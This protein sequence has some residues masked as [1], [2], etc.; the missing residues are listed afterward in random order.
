MEE[1][2]HAATVPLRRGPWRQG[3]A[4]VLAEALTPE[5]GD[6]GRVSGACLQAHQS[7]P[8]RLL[9]HPLGQA[10]PDPTPPQPGRDHVIVE[11]T[12][13]WVAALRSGAQGQASLSPDRMRPGV[14][15]HW[16]PSCC[17]ARVYTYITT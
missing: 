12:D 5:S 13:R 14:A 6:S 7:Q 4:A 8:A 9:D 17:G 16:L 3:K 1:H 11:P 15:T 2:F 10:R